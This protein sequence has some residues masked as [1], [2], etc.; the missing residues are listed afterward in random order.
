MTDPTPA[1]QR[2]LARLAAIGQIGMEMAV[3]VGVGVGLDFWWGTLPWCTI[4]GALLG[5]IL[6]FI[7][8]MAL[9]K[10]PADTPS[11]TKK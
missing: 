1:D 9:L 8:L 10:P 5:P 11:D 7:H 2:K 4:I 3:P 6:G